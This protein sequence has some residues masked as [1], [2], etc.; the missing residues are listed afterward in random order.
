ML[1]ERAVHLIRPVRSSACLPSPLSDIR[2]LPLVPK[3][4]N[5]DATRIV[6]AAPGDNVA[7]VLLAHAKP[8]IRPL[9]WAGYFWLQEI[10]TLSQVWEEG[11]SRSCAFT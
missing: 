2:S 10:G 11:R 6:Q 7:L 4:P 3:G 1:R 8:P 9:C 5:S